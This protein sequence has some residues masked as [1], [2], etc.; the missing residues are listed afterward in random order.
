MAARRRLAPLLS[1]LGIA[2]AVAALSSPAAS[3]ERSE[4]SLRVAGPRETVF[5]WSEDACAPVEQPDLP[6]RAFR[7]ARGRVQLLL[8]SY[9]T[10]RLI[11]PSLDR[12]RTD[13]RP[14][15]RSPEDPDPSRYRDRRWIASPYTEDGRRVW[16]LVHHEYQGHRHPGRCPQRSYFRCWYNAVTLATSA[17]GGASYRQPRPP[18]QLVAGPPFRYRPGVG[19]TGVFAPSNVVRWGGHLYALVRVRDGARRAGV[20]LL[21]ARWPGRPPAWRAW[22]DGRFAVRFDDPYLSRGKPSVGCDRISPGEISEMTESLTFNT[23]LDRFLLVGI[24]APFGAPGRRTAGV[25]YSLSE[26]L[27]HWAPRRLLMA[28]PTLQAHRCGG[29]PPVAYPSLLSPDSASRSFATTGAR[30]YLYFTVFHL[31]RCR[32]TA[33]RDLVR[34][35]VEVDG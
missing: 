9:E 3:P 25:Y 6:A 27:V 15:L 21:R 28:A 20:C 35:R 1:L 23:A 24:A 4:P 22:A 26:D 13:C 16:A 29:R 33:D 8:S 19:P 32:R 5:D 12:L 17:D 34:V 31:R 30:P 11:G 10:F 14:V 2:L 7:D 18:R